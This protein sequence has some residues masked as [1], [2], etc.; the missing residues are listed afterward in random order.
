MR[1]KKI[2][3]AIISVITIA[4]IV[5]TAVVCG[6]YGFKRSTKGLEYSE[7]TDGTYMVMGK[8]TSTESDIVINR[9]KTKKV[10]KIS[11]WAFAFRESISSVSMGDSVISIGNNAF[12]NCIAL[13]EVTIGKNLTDIGYSAF[14][15]CSSLTS[16]T[17]PSSVDYI[18]EMAFSGC[19][20]LK[21]IEIP[22]GVRHI[23]DST[24]YWCSSLNSIVIPA[25]VMSIGSNAFQYCSNLDAIYFGGSKADWQDMTIGYNNE[26]LLDADVYFYSESQM[27]SQSGTHYWRY[28]DGVPT[29]W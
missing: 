18:G 8:G 6:V 21:S 13:K 14:Y 5:A 19:T 9:Y 10:T 29:K 1:E 22:S 28:V 17:L 27:Y 12:Y 4:L 20:A 2:M 15:G 26:Y 24:F 23:G 25:S 11:N 3:L 7:N 16:V